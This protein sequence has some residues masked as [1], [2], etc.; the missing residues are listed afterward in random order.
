MSSR[1]HGSSHSHVAQPSRRTFVKGLAMGGVVAGLGLW[2]DSA[3]AQTAPRQQSAVLSG[4]QFDLTI[5]ER[6]MS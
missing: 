3:W 6:V 2:R 4:T 5:G 1:K